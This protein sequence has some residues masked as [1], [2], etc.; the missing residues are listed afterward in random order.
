MEMPT[1]EDPKTPAV[2]DLQSV[3]WGVRRP[4]G[5]AIGRAIA[6]GRSGYADEGNGTQRRAN[7]GEDAVIFHTIDFTSKPPSIEILCLI[8]V[9]VITAHIARK[10]HS[11]QFFWL[12]FPKPRIEIVIV[13]AEHLLAR[14]FSR[15]ARCNTCIHHLHSPDHWQSLHLVS[16]MRRRSGARTSQYC[17]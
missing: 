14:I 3:T 5:G 4:G 2:E 15:E 16:P 9:S 13:F 11:G 7:R 12:V 8:V 1:P 17:S 10:D 6:T